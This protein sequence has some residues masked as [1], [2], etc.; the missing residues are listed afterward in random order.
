LIYFF[1]SSSQNQ[2]LFVIKIEI[3]RAKGDSYPDR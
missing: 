1:Q 3:E 2:R